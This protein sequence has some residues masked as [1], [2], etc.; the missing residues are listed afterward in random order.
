MIKAII[1]IILIKVNK[2]IIID[3][4]VKVNKV[5]IITIYYNYDYKNCPAQEAPSRGAG[6][7]YSLERKLRSPNPRFLS[8]RT[9]DDYR[10]LYSIYERFLLL[11][12]LQRAHWQ[13]AL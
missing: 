13:P 7:E 8:M 2:V 12:S 3:I 10:T 11:P 4:L 1:L 5:I 9:S 6:C